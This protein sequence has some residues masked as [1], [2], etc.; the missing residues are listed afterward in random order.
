[1][2]EIRT[3][4]KKKMAA[5]GL[6]TDERQ[7]RRTVGSSGDKAGVVLLNVYGNVYEDGACW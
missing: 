1:M 7:P 2:Q 3:R 5:Q 6:W 4:M